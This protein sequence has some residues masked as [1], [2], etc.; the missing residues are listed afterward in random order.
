MN[1]LIDPESERTKRLLAENSK[2]NLL[3]VNSLIDQYDI[4]FVAKMKYHRMGDF[5]IILDHM[6]KSLMT[7]KN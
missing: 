7:C 4:N 5:N 3:L 1:I 2:T 6:H